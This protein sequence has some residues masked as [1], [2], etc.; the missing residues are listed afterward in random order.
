[1]VIHTPS[2]T[3]PQHS[4]SLVYHTVAPDQLSAHPYLSASL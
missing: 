2:R 4:V 3:G 1:M